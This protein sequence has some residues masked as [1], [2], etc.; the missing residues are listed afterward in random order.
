MSLL[1]DLNFF[2][3]LDSGSIDNAISTPAAPGQAFGGS[4]SGS[5]S[6]GLG[7][8]FFGPLSFLAP[9]TFGDS[10]GLGPDETVNPIYL[11]QIRPTQELVTDENSK[12]YALA[13]AKQFNDAGYNV[14]GDGTLAVRPNVNPFDLPGARGGQGI[15]QT[16]FGDYDVPT[17]KSAFAD[18]VTH[19][20]W[21]PLAGLGNGFLDQI[22]GLLG[23]LGKELVIGAAVVVG[24][25]VVLQLVRR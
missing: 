18:G 21:D 11:P 16:P 9:G 14:A 17:F 19:A 4:G 7:A 6:L 15:V 22:N 12:A 2:P 5:P 3:G 13:H 23:G 1:D 25:I 8:V 10:A 20:I 24:A